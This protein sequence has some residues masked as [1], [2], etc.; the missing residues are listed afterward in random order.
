MSDSRRLVKP[1]ASPAS[2]DPLT[3]APGPEAYTRWRATTLG[4]VTEAL[5]QRVMLELV[6]PVKD[7]RVLDLGCG[8]GLL[9]TALAERGAW[10]VGI[11]LDRLMLRAATA[12]PEPRPCRTPRFI[13]GRIEE[14][15]FPNAM[16][17]I[18]VAVTVLCFLSD[19]TAAVREAARVL[20]PGGR[21]VIGDLGRWS[22]WAARRRVRGWLGSRLWRAAH[23][24][25]AAEL[26]ALVERAGLSV[27][28]VR[29]SVYYPPIGFLARALAPLDHWLGPLTTAGAAFIALAAIKEHAG[30]VPSQ[31]ASSETV[32][33]RRR[34]ADCD[35]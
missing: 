7:K 28:T 2:S 3:G 31:T 14:L 22:A 24:S 16:F 10:A 33:D 17:D 34:G 9:T 6:G 19:P 12:R 32:S 1:A 18:V 29:G 13:Q 27:E 8:D 26:S 25:T 21:L 15:P 11:D 4:A 23:F 20:R 35:S 30:D 5:E